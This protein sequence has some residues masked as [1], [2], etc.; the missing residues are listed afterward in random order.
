MKMYNITQIDRESI[1]EMH[2]K[3]K[4]PLISEQ[5][6]ADLKGQL[7]KIL[8]D[9]CVKN[10]KIV[11][12]QTKN[13]ALQFAIK[14]ESTK[15]PGKFRY[16]FAD[17]RA[18]IFDANGKFQ[19]LPGKL[20]CTE[21]Q[22][23][24]LSDKEKVEKD[25]ETQLTTDAKN[26]KDAYILKF[27][28][29]PYNYQFNVEDIN[30]QN[31]TELDPVNDLRVPAGIFAVTDKF[32]SDPSLN[33]DIKGSDDSVLDKV[34]DNQS[35]NRNA[36]RKNIEDY[37]KSYKR[38]N[39]VEIDAAKIIKAKRI[40]QSCKDEHYGKWGVLGGGNKLDEMLDIMSGGSGGPLTYG[41]TSIWLLKN[42]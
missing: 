7:N 10:G 20:D 16:F 26:K 24:K 18:G 5:V 12:M 37:Y 22:Q 36:C 4:K 14:Q 6:V 32:Y 30:K 2:S 27:S 38:R 42:N 19:F 23:Q 11:T 31:F 8:T 17:G 3:M 25:K 1:L 28:G 13:P 29:A 41:E 21:V 40:V 35:V 15:T 33:K 9:G 39:S 34:L